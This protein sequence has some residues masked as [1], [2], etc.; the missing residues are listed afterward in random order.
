MDHRRR[1]WPDGVTLTN[2]MKTDFVR[3]IEP[4][5]E[6]G[7]PIADK[8]KDTLRLWLAQG[9]SWPAAI[10]FPAPRWKALPPPPGRWILSGMWCPILAQGGPLSAGG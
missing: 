1:V 4:I 5:F 3:D 7:A 6:K 2:V 10:S 8:A 9:A